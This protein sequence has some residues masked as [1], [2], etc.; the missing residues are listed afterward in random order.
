MCYSCGAG[1]A[2]VSVLSFGMCIS[3]L[4]PGAAM[5]ASQVEAD[6]KLDK[7]KASLHILNASGESLQVA[8]DLAT[9]KHTLLSKVTPKQTLYA[10]HP[11]L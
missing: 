3:C 1:V 9:L 6:R 7:A 10:L 11:T 8:S 4:G 2:A 5:G